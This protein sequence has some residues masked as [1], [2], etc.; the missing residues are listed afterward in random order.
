M[1]DQDHAGGVAGTS[2]G[3]PPGATCPR[4]GAGDLRPILY[5][6][7][8]P[9]AFDAA[10]RGQLVLGGCVVSDDGP[11]VACVHGGTRYS[12]RPWGHDAEVSDA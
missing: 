2:G 10:A 1:E 11:T 9:Q 7:P 8:T 12:D 4:C 6:L 5:G 3:L